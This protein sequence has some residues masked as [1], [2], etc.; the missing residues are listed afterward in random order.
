M[1]VFVHVC[2]EA[3]KV[4]A[5]RKV[6]LDISIG[7]YLTNTSKTVLLIEWRKKRERGLR[8]INSL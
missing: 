6:N 8:S 1:H 7:L 4:G 5:I 3:T 2:E